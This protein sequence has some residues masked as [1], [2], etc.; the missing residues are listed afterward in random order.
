MIR[1]LERSAGKVYGMETEGVIDLEQ[2]EALR[3]ELEALIAKHG[4][5]NV[6]FHVKSMKG[7]GF[8]EFVADV[9]FAIKHW[10][11]IGKV[12][13]VSDKHWWAIGVKIDNLFTRWEERFFEPTE[14]EQA[15]TWVES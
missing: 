5:I 11:D 1:K 12:A 7:Y 3:P 13:I 10:N 2:F 6:L 4:K 14:L 9:K 8:K 15:W